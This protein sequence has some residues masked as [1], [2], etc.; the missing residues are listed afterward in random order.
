MSLFDSAV[1]VLSRGDRR[2]QFASGKESLIFQLF[3]SNPPPAFRT[4]TYKPPITLLKLAM[5]TAQETLDAAVLAYLIK[6]GYTRSVKAFQK[7][8]DTKPSEGAKLE[9]VWTASLPA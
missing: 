9:A 4:R 1:L 6:K 7:E 8:A 5:S 3:S 2:D